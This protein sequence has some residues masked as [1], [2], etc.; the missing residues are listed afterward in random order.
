M[1]LPTRLRAVPASGGR[2]IGAAAHVV[3]G[4]TEPS[5]S[6]GPVDTESAA[7]RLREAAAEVRVRLGERAA[8]SKGVAKSLLEMSAIIAEDPML[9]GEAERLIREEGLE[10]PVAMWRAGGEIAGKLR[11]VGGTT[12]ERAADVLDVRDRIVARLLGVPVPGVPDCC[13]PFVL[14]AD[15][16]APSDTATLDPELVLAIVT[17]HGGPTSHTAILARELGIPAVVGCE[18][19]LEIPEGMR[20][21]VDG[22]NGEVLLSFDDETEF[23]SHQL[24]AFDYHGPCATA[25]GHAVE[26]LANVGDAE[27]ARIAAEVGADGIGLLRTEYCFPSTV[28]PSVEEQAAKYGEVFAHFPGRRVI[29]RTLDAG[30]DKPHAYL[31]HAE[32]PN[33]AL[34]VRGYRAMVSHPQ[35]LDDQ[36]AAIR[37]A[38]DAHDAEVWVMAPMITTPDEAEEFVNKAHA[39]GL[40]TA[41]VMVEVPA[42]AVRASQVL[43]RAD[44][45]SIGT[46]DLA[47]YTMAADRNLADVAHLTDAWDPAILTLIELTTQGGDRQGRPVG[48]CGESAA[49]PAMAVV[50]VGLG[51][52][53]LSMSPRSLPAVAAVIGRTTYEECVRLAELALVQENAA[54]AHDAVRSQLPILAELDL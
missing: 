46:N 49:D 7:T 27:G 29:I 32:E 48:V 18:R 40:S 1:S 28:A 43:A 24:P 26:M 16:L 38:A 15:E 25:D 10:A 34:G 30:A 6:G 33:P 37:L 50:L 20:I 3:R 14:L 45:A 12:A 11:A 19:C 13:A 5:A 4:L 39:A 17:K 2:A 35:V 22:T 41:G 52:T 42:A 51:V 31:S 44:F 53:S 47:Q 54:A 9:L 23:L 8:T 36:L 21:A